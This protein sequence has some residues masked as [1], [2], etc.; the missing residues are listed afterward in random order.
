MVALKMAQ[1]EY[2]AMEN[3]LLKDKNDLKSKL[4]EQELAHQEVIRQLKMVSCH[5]SRGKITNN[6]VQS[7]KNLFTY[8]YEFRNKVQ[9]SVSRGSNLLKM[10]WSWNGNMRHV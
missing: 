3:E 6:T 5:W 9:R 10:H 1:D 8:L 7:C 2:T 4:R